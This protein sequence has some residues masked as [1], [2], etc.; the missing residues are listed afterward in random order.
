MTQ[1]ELILALRKRG[2]LL[3]EWNALYRELMDSEAAG[4]L[5][6]M[7]E[8]G[9]FNPMDLMGVMGNLK[10]MV[11]AMKRIKELS[12]L[13]ITLDT[14]ILEGMTGFIGMAPALEG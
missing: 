14:Q 2:A 3:E 13:L 6:G 12:E 5:T 7:A 4:L 11:G 8:G 9:Q 10:P 1:P